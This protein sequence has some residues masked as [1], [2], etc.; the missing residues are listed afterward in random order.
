MSAGLP[1][2]AGPS[3]ETFTYCTTIM[4]KE[5]GKDAAGIIER[6]CKR[7]KKLEGELAKLREDYDKLSDKL[8]LIED[9]HPMVLDTLKD[10]GMLDD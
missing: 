9:L 5:T 4:S 2:R 7:I 3:R 1:Y 6:Q 10:H 8:E